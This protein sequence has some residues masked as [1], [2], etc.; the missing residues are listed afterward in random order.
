MK[1]IEVTLQPN[2]E[3]PVSFLWTKVITRIHLRLTFLQDRDGVV[4]VALA[5]PQYS[6]S[7]PSLGTK[8]R[9]VAE[10]DKH[11]EELDIRHTFAIYRDYVHIS[12]I[13]E[14]PRHAEFVKFCRVQPKTSVERI[15]RRKAKREN[16]PYESALEKLKTFKEKKSPF[17]YVQLKSSSTHQNYSLFIRREEFEASADFRFNTYG[18]SRGGAVPDF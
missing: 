4:P 14:V 2:A 13:R 18:L 17:P 10:D 12:G 11:L 7:P 9:I 3:I 8:F 1:Y 16:I 6:E 15:A 5:F